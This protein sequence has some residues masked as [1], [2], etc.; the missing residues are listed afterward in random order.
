M[1]EAK[2][3][4]MGIFQG[5]P[6]TKFPDALLLVPSYPP[7][8]AVIQAFLDC[9]YYF[10]CQLPVLLKDYHTLKSSFIFVSTLCVPFHTVSKFRVPF[11]PASLVPVSFHYGRL[12][13]CQCSISI[14][15][16]SF[17]QYVTFLLP[18]LSSCSL[19]V[20]YVSS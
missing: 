8:K 13:T 20:F 4:D 19:S 2:L 1:T 6:G 14:P 15:S 10:R 9:G 5:M 18:L 16:L 11:R 7:S 17:L 3:T 12:V